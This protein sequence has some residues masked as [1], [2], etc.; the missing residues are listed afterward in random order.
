MIVQFLPV[1]LLNLL[2]NVVLN[3]FV[4]QS[5]LWKVF[6]AHHSLPELFIVNLIYYSETYPS[7]HF[8]LH[9][10]VSELVIHTQL[11]R[12]TIRVIMQQSAVRTGKNVSPQT[13]CMLWFMLFLRL[14]LRVE[15]DSHAIHRLPLSKRRTRKNV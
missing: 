10:Q 15:K 6:P 4:D 2:S 3:G 1:G 5:L 8:I 12:K 7:S 11:C 13:S 14:D 9:F